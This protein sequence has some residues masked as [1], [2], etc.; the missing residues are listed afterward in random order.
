M[1]V[2]RKYDK[3]LN[4]FCFNSPNLCWK[5]KW[6][7]VFHFKID[8]RK[9]SEKLMHC[10]CLS[11]QASFLGPWLLC[12]H[13][14]ESWPHYF[15]CI[16][17]TLQ[18]GQVW[19]WVLGFLWSGLNNERQHPKTIHYLPPHGQTVSVENLVKQQTLL[20]AWNVSANYHYFVLNIILRS[21]MDNY[22]LYMPSPDQWRG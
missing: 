8:Y 22:T 18:V 11:L 15:D 4:F 7:K 12:K 6:V 21:S 17:H 5:R 20:V 14:L 13:L 9:C 16:R 10:N 1:L 3:A 2:S 19:G